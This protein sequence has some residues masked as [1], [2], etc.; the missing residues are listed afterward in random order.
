VKLPGHP[1]D[2]SRMTT[3]Q[4]NAELEK[5]YARMQNKQFRLS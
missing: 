3:E 2:V 5:G 4:L 1:L